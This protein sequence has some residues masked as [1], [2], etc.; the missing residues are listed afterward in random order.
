MPTLSA[1]AAPASL[2]ATPSPNAGPV[3]Y[4][5]ARGDSLSLIAARYNTTWQSLVYW[6]RTGYPSLNPTEPT[7]D[8]NRIQVGW[9]LTVWPGVIVDYHP[10]IA[11]P[12]PSVPVAGSTTLVYHGARSSGTVALTFDMGGRTEPAVAIVRWLRDHGIPATIFL[13]GAAVDGS[14][15]AREVISIIN[16]RPDLFDMGNHSYSHPEMTLLTWQQV[17]DQLHSAELT[18]DRYAEQSPRPL[19]RPPYGAWDADV[20]KG[21]AA[22]GYSRTVLWDVDTLDWKAISDGGPTAKQIVSNVLLHAQGG[23]IVLMHLGGFETLN[24]LPA[25]VSGLRAGGYRLVTL[26]TMLGV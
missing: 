16:A 18:I 15:D 3:V 17:Y 10:P 2:S 19:F 13:T 1:T 9:R 14:A 11:T 8:P 7:Y 21:A 23:S 22:A 26:G 4:V 25:I 20:L 6:N 12:T 24:A 5:V